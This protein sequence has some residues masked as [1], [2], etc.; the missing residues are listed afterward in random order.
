VLHLP[1]LAFILLSQLFICKV[2]QTTSNKRQSS[3]IEPVA[4]STASKFFF[5]I[6]HLPASFAHK[7]TGDSVF[8]PS[9][10]CLALSTPQ[11]VTY[12][13]NEKDSRQQIAGSFRSTYYSVSFAEWSFP[14]M[15]Q[16]AGFKRRSRFGQTSFCC[17]HS[18]TKNFS[19]LTSR[20]RGT[21]LPGNMHFDE[22]E[23]LDRI[24]ANDEMDRRCEGLCFN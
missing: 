21:I 1:F 4:A 3:S 11:V 6:R 23:V 24:S 8:L 14:R 18:A 10:G 13:E 19:H 20:T 9:D 2:T 22:R 12:Y 17:L 7:T 5:V 16:E 15:R